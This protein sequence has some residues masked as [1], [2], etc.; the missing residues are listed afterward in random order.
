MIG[1]MDKRITIRGRSITR[2]NGV[3]T[4]NGWQTIE[5]VYGSVEPMN[6]YEQRIAQQD[7]LIASHKITMRYRSDLG[8]SNTELLPEHELVIDGINH[9]IR[10]VLNRDFRNKWYDIMTEIRL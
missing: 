5:T 3:K 1:K 2:V 10:Q 8:E 6:G 4:D 9:E 7:G